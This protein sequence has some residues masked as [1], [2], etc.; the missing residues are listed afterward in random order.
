MRRLR[1]SASLASLASFAFVLSALLAGCGGDVTAGGSPSAARPITLN[2]FA[3]ASLKDAFTAIGNSFHAAHPNVTVTFNFAGSDTLAQQ[4]TQG[5]APA[6]V[7]ASANPQQMNVVV[8]GGDID[9]G[10]VKVFT[11]NRIEVIFPKNNPAHIQTLQDLA[12]PG[13]KLVLAAP[14]VPA[15]QYARDF[16][17]RASDD[18]SFPAG[19]KDAVLKNVV[20]SESDVKSVLAKVTLGEADAGIVYTTDAA[21]KAD[22]LGTLA[23]PDNLNTIAVYPIGVVKGSKQAATAQQF[24]NAVLAADGQ[25][26]LA[27]FG[28]LPAGQGPQYTPPAGA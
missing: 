1:T 19:Y 11:H 22:D 4:I 10:K 13:L 9:G 16:L 7:F 17:T 26:T 3:A 8:K 20:S 27:R 18:T 25:A 28:F 2:V 24:V 5:G 23:I 12:K 21:T 14:A 6:D 15:G